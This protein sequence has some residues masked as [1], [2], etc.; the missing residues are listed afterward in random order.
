MEEK[1]SSNPPSEPILQDD[2]PPKDKPVKDKPVKGKPV[3]GKPVKDK[4]VK[5]KPVK[6][7]ETP[8]KTKNSQLK[9]TNV[10]SNPVTD[11]AET[12]FMPI[13]D[14]P[15]PDDPVAMEAYKRALGI[16]D[17]PASHNTATSVPPIPPATV[18]TASSL[19]NEDK[20][21]ESPDRLFT[22]S[23]EKKTL[24]NTGTGY[25]LTSTS[26]ET[27]L[28]GGDDDI[29]A[30]EFVQAAIDP[31][32]D[33]VIESGEDS[34]NKERQTTSTQ[35]SE[36]VES[37]TELLSKV[38]LNELLTNDIISDS[39]N[40]QP[41]KDQEPL[42]PVGNTGEHLDQRSSL[43]TESG[44]DL[45][46]TGTVAAAKVA[47]QNN[48]F[49]LPRIFK[50]RVSYL[51]IGGVFIACAAYVIPRLL[52]LPELSDSED[53]QP[54]SYG[55]WEA[56][57]QLYAEAGLS[58]EKYAEG[59]LLLETL[60]LSQPMS[61]YHFS[62]FLIDDQDQPESR[63][64]IAGSHHN[65]SLTT[66]ERHKARM[67][68]KPDTRGFFNTLT[69]RAFT[70]W[71]VAFILD[72]PEGIDLTRDWKRT[73]AAMAWHASFWFEYQKGLAG[74]VFNPVAWSGMSLRKAGKYVLAKILTRP[75]DDSLVRRLVLAI[76]PKQ[77]YTSTYKPTPSEAVLDILDLEPSKTQ[78]AP[79][80]FLITASKKA[81]K[82][83]WVIS[84]Q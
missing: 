7:K 15:D 47:Q 58:A 30:G 21:L 66:S 33:P 82:P 44:T 35:E 62:T 13:D 18:S 59:L 29:T 69:D 12:D 31:V 51:A 27:D 10:F 20:P 28:V 37:E 78:T 63:W 83:L 71:F 16:S 46:K 75:V 43:S 56:V 39:F 40:G 23:S 5:D 64:T 84:I 50:N 57:A 22:N 32:I 52:S 74:T 14:F 73:Q 76:E 2:P 49:Q 80:S 11:Y 25:S 4:P 70:Q 19:Y 8:K 61:F 67:L 79:L 48:P 38:I 55:R 6:D 26:T 17:S 41:L 72:L 68:I 24:D 60:K 45:L 34:E 65:Q 1:K 36:K 3:K 81:N 77:P 54:K 9:R 42:M 53:T